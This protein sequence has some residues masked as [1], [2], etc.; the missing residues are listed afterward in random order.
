[1]SSLGERWKEQR[2]RMKQTQCWFATQLGIST[3]YLSLIE[4]GNRKRPSVELI[5][6]AAVVSGRSFKHMAGE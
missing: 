3:S 2:L 5:R 4:S 6:K 1:M